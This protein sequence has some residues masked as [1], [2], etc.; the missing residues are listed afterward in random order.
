MRYLKIFCIPAVI[1]MAITLCGAY[2]MVNMEK[3]SEETLS[4][5]FISSEPALI[6]AGYI[7]SNRNIKNCTEVE[8]VSKI[9]TEES[10]TDIAKTVEEKQ[11]TVEEKQVKI[12][13]TNLNNTA[14]AETSNYTDQD[15][16]I[17]SNGV[18]KYVP[19]G[20]GKTHTFMGWQL[21]TS[22]S[23][24]Q[25]KL[26]SFAGEN[27]DSNGFAKIGDRF[28]VATKPYYG[29]I[30]DYIDVYKSN[31]EVI[32]CVIGDQKG[33][34]GGGDMYGHADGSIIEFVVDKY[35]WYSAH[36]GLGRYLSVGEFYPSWTTNSIIKIVHV[37]NFWQSI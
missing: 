7:I 15:A 3:D 28:V 10:K 1:C 6:T 18:E 36:N 5:S 9:E 11:V 34:D 4:N 31:G 37:G 30:G 35:T 8:E 33:S 12:S 26:R 14:V 2:Y 25:Y 13:D 27:Y 24:A 17:L 23:S 22:P 16:A 21:I 32:K 20:R 19:P 29:T